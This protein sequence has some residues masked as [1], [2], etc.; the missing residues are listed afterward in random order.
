[1][2]EPDR[3]RRKYYPEENVNPRNHRN[4]QELPKSPK[5]AQLERFHVF[6]DS[7]ESIN[8]CLI[9]RCVCPWKLTDYQDVL[10]ESASRCHDDE[11]SNEIL[12]FCSVIQLLCEEIARQNSVVSRSNGYCRSLRKLKVQLFHVNSESDPTS[13]LQNFIKSPYQYV[14]YAAARA[15]SSWLKAADEGACRVLLDRLLENIVSPLA[16]SLSTLNTS[17]THGPLPHTVSNLLDILKSCIE[18]PDIEPH[19]TEGATEDEDEESNFTLQGIALVSD[20]N[21]FEFIKIF[22]L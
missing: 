9:T 2:G 1:M 10:I 19:P 18:V 4:H 6:H 8:K 3:K 16:T 22:R 20:Y 12:L 5:S 13:A 11:N 14:S 21:I 7:V 17:G 15:L